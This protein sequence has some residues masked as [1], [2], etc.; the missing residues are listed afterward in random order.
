M[1]EKIKEQI[2]L[3]SFFL[4]LSLFFLGSMICF[5]PGREAVWF[6][7][8]AIIT[9]PAFFSKNKWLKFFTLLILILSL[10]LSFN[11]FQRGKN[12]QRLMENRKTEYLYNEKI[13]LE[14]VS[15]RRPSEDK[16][17]FDYAGVLLD[18]TFQE[19]EKQSASIKRSFDID[20]VVMI[21]P[22]LGENDIP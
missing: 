8:V 5:V 13:K 6:L 15:F 7:P 18:D 4:A 16:F 20:F 21:I 2:S 3:M 17:C 10:K 22:T 14:R 11:A 19:I 9:V 12:Y 1:N